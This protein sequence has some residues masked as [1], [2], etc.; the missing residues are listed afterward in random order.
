M[1]N[2]HCDVFIL[3][4][5]FS[6][7]SGGEGIYITRISGIYGVNFTSGNYA[8]EVLHGQVLQRFLKMKDISTTLQLLVVTYKV[9]LASKLQDRQGNN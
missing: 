2:V 5:L 4:K 8:N 6:S 3:L 7:M 9:C 1:Q